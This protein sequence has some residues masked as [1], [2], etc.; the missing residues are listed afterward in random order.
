MAILDQLFVLGQ[1]AVPQHSLSRVMGRMAN[2]K[3]PRIKNTVIRKFIKYYGVNMDEA[4]RSSAE[5]YVDFNDFFTR[6]LKE[7]ARPNQAS[8]STIACPADGTVSRAGGIE[9]GRIFQAKGHSFSLIDLLGGDTRRA[10]PFMA[11]DFTTIYLAPKDYHRVHM[12]CHGELKEMIHVPGKLFSVNPST[13]EHVGRLFARNER[14]VCLFT[15]AFGPM[16]LVM[17]GAMIVA[18]IAT[19]WSGI[20]APGDKQIRHYDYQPGEVVLQQGEQVGHFCLGSTVILLFP[21]DTIGLAEDLK[22]DQSV[23]LGSVI[24]T[25][26]GGSEK[27]QN[28][29]VARLPKT[30]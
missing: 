1:H 24:G 25:L 29:S 6:E 18:S 17:V 30:P 10:Q 28:N 12:P 16:A 2:C 27:D 14:V 7:S 20:V 3:I 22:P 13:T 9:Y 8:K 4:L 15:T 23:R 21:E 26:K 5:D 11:G 19:V